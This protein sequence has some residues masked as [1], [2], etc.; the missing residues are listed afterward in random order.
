VADHVGHSRAGIG[1]NGRATVPSRAPC[2]RVARR[3]PCDARGLLVVVLVWGCHGVRSPPSRGETDPVAAPACRQALAALRAASDR[4]A[5][6]KADD[7]CGSRRPLM[8]G[9]PDC[10]WAVNRIWWR[11]TEAEKLGL[12]MESECGRHHV[13]CHDCPVLCIEG[14]CTL[15]TSSD[16]Q[17][18]QNP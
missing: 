16:P 1:G 3:R 14:Q 17:R 11:S 9:Q 13:P 8:V 12:H 4:N 6:C 5:T 18:I 15:A 10:C 2:A 7:E